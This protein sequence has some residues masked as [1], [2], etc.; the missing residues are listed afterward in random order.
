MKRTTARATL[1]TLLFSM[2]AMICDTALMQ[3]PAYAAKPTPRPI[4][5]PSPRLPTKK[6]HTEFLVEVNKK[7]QIV[8]VRSGKSCDN[9]TFNAQTYGNVL[10]M[11]IRHP[12]GTAEVGVYRVT[13]DYNPATRKIVRGVALVNAGG[14]WGDK[15]GAANEM[16]DIARRNATRQQRAQATP[17]PANLPSLES[18]TGS[19]P[20]PSPTSHN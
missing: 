15:E 13:Y 17:P 20:H 14:N 2:C 11:W 16:M 8:R 4:V 18:I 1:A 6:L 5:L 10:Q 7:G 12:D 9:L 3:Q 19:H